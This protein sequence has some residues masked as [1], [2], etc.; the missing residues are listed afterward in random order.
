[1]LLKVFFISNLKKNKI[2]TCEHLCAMWLGADD[3]SEVLTRSNNAVEMN[4]LTC[5]N[6]QVTLIKNL[7]NMLKWTILTTFSQTPS[8]W[9]KVI[10]GHLAILFRLLIK[11]TPP[12]G[13][14]SMQL[15]WLR[16]SRTGPVQSEG[17]LPLFILIKC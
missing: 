10:M 2:C 14:T 13:T 17:T 15:T 11:L 4:N 8:V 5:N 3:T 12:T 9:T 6:L 1:M 16:N 7:N